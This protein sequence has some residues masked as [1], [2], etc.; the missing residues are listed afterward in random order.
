MD[1]YIVKELD[2]DNVFILPQP[3]SLSSRSQVNLE[4]TFNFVNNLDED[5]DDKL[6]END[7]NIENKDNNNNNNDNI[8]K[9]REIKSKWTGIP[10]IAANMDTIGTFKVYD[11]L[12][13]YKMLT[14]LNKF[15]TVQDYINAVK[16]GIDLDP[17]YFMVTTGITEENFKNLREI[18]LYTNC[19][20]ICI[21]VANGYMNCFVDFCYRIRQLYPDKIIVAG[22]VVTEEMVNKLVTKGGVDI[23][24]VGIGSGSA[25]LTRRQTG[26][27]R[28][29]L[30]AVK[31]CAKMCRSL[32]S[33]GYSAYIVSDGGIK[34]PG[35]MA[36][37]F[38]AGADFVMA[39]GIFSGHDE[40]PGE[41]I[42]ENGQHFKMFYGMSSKHA[43]EKY[44]GKMENY[45]SSEGAV[46]KVPYK[47]PI[48]Y[49]IQDFLG[50]LRS[51]CTYIGAE[52]IEQMPYKTYFVAI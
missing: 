49:T 1:N 47:G 33:V 2:F 37:A 20:W 46:I 22:N 27:G 24:K 51:T 32:R 12:R 48:E 34:Y 10:I 30:H 4:R 16:S 3:S 8:V 39:G 25:C 26:V 45:R 50:G 31:E 15:Y 19:K 13:K 21:D 28:P 6:D 40:N 44:F 18:V 43:M 5:E 9:H 38:G 11:S 7:C 36:K 41:I 29:Q 14:A 42:E 17:E 23:V 35:D 52:C